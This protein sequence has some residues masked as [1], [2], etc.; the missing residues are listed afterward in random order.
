MWEKGV[1]IHEVKEIRSGSKIYFGVGAINKIYDVIQDLKKKEIYKILVV[2]GKKSYKLSGAWGPIEKALNENSI[3]YKIYDGITPNPTTHQ[4]DEATKMGLDLGAGAVLSIGGGSP[5]DAGK[6]VAILLK[7]TEKTARELYEYKFTPEEAVPIIA[8]NLTHGTGTEADRF[9]VVNI[10]ETE[11]KPSIGYD[12]I[13]PLISINDPAF[14]VKLPRN[15][16]LYVTIDAMNHVIESCSNTETS[17]LAILFTK[18]TIRLINKYLPVALENP[19]DLTA[20]YYLM[21]AAMIAGISFDST[22]LH[23]TH[24]LEHPLSGIKPELSHGL[25]LSIL[26]PAV[27]KKVYASRSEILADVLEPIIPGLTGDPGEA[28]KAAEGIENWLFDLGIKSKLS[29]EG[30]KE[31][32]IDILTRQVFETP[33]LAGLL[34]LSPI[35]AD[36]TTV[37]DIYKDSF[38]SISLVNAGN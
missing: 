17:P 18:E 2:T 38:V 22:R 14:A 30:F 16:T 32:D 26:L 31:E 24:A 29:D 23:F 27:I 9:A 10:P 20:R 15:Q 33:S 34:K 37:R 7:N 4:V 35:P 19:E 8:V 36:E 21:Y 1:N 28:E 6:S 12:C 11:T 3:E 13:Y 25:G 5:I